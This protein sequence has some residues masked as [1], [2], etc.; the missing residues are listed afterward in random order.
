MMLLT[1]NSSCK[2]YFNIGPKVM[3]S[4]ACCFQDLTKKLETQANEIE[5]NRKSKDKQLIQL[6]D[7]YKKQMELVHVLRQQK[8]RSL[9]SKNILGFYNDDIFAFPF[10]ASP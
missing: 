3:A 1:H 6:V 10:A 2:Q 8:V 9:A 4:S 5:T 7:A